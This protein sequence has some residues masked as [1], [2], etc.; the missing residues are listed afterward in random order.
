MLNVQFFRFVVCTPLDKSR[1]KELKQLLRYIKDE[2]NERYGF[3]ELLS[4]LVEEPIRW[5]FPD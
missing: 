2:T 3:A 5:V 4:S 1:K